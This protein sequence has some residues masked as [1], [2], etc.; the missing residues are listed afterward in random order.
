[1]FNYPLFETKT[2]QRDLDRPGPAVSKRIRAALKRRVY[3]ALRATPRNA[4]SA[5]RLQHAGPPTWRIRIG[6][7]RIFYEIA[8]EKRIVFLTA[9]DYRKNADR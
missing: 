9:A 2:Y 5:A 8:H 1:M 7:W 3:P 4:A 6:S